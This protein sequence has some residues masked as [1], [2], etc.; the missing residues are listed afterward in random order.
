[1]RHHDRLPVIALCTL[2]LLIVFAG[3][4]VGIVHSLHADPNIVGVGLGVVAAVSIVLLVFRRHL[5]SLFSA[6]RA[7]I[8]RMEDGM[9]EDYSAHAPLGQQEYPALPA[10]GQA[11]RAASFDDDVRE[12]GARGHASEYYTDV[13]TA[14]GEPVLMLA[15]NC[16]L[17]F[18]SAF[19]HTLIYEDP[20]TGRRE[21]SIAARLYV[22]LF[23]TLG[24]IPQLILTR[25]PSYA[26]VLPY[27]ENGWL[28]GN[29]EA[30]E[31]RLSRLAHSTGGEPRYASID[32]RNARSFVKKAITFGVQ[33]VVDLSTY[34][35]LDQEE[36]V[37]WKLL[38]GALEHEQPCLIMLL[39]ADHWLSRYPLAALSYDNSPSPKASFKAQIQTCVE[40]LIASR[41][42]AVYLI[43]SDLSMLDEHLAKRCVLWLLNREPQGGMDEALL[44]YRTG[45]SEEG[46]HCL[47]DRAILADTRSK[48]AMELVLHR[49]QS[50]HEEPGRATSRQLDLSQIAADE[51]EERDRL[52]K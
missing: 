32:E 19:N 2:V 29:P 30:R 36:R 10:P 33:T 51:E 9:L 7:R 47:R 1:M 8:E 4:L 35:N 18:S 12:R 46:L 17:P 27:V 39:E 44:C 31:E 43:T 21:R 23:G 49:H 34:T 48:T 41:H 11:H 37:V 24:S 13:E 52:G 42:A 15:D 38:V 3:P 25:N 45:L 14:Q 5:G 20:A 26:S 16:P 6:V 40:Q 22:E 28:A 50:T